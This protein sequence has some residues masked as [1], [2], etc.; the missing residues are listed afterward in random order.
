MNLLPIVKLLHL[1]HLLLQDV[2][3]TVKLL[4]LRLLVAYLVSRPLQSLL[5]LGVLVVTGA[6]AILFPFFFRGGDHGFSL[7]LLFFLFGHPLG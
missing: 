6:F 3:F 4:F 7:P 1:L 2:Q 5:K